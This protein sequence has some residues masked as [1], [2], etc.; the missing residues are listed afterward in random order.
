MVLVDD[1]ESYSEYNRRS[2]EDMSVLFDTDFVL[3]VEFD[4]CIVNPFA[5]TDEFFN[6]DYIGAPW[7][8]FNSNMKWYY[9]D[10]THDKDLLV[11]NSGFSLRSKKLCDALSSKKYGSIP[12]GE[13]EDVFICQ[14]I[15]KELT[16]D[17][18]KFAPFDVAARFS[19]ENQLYCGQFGAHHGFYLS[20]GMYVNMKGR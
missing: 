2:I 6:Y 14:N 1:C 7:I 8:G 3:T 17:G 15:R 18:I 4:S 13:P 5:W 19:V 16:N 9:W 12:E 10:G 20:N 11:G